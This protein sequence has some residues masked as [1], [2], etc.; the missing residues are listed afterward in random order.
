MMEMVL[1]VVGMFILVIGNMF[2][3]V[4]FLV[5]VFLVV[6]L[7]DEIFCEVFFLVIFFEGVRDGVSLLRVFLGCM[8]FIILVRMIFLV[9]VGW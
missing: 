3:V 5:I 2:I 8:V 1:G 7:C 6:I 4:F 9:L